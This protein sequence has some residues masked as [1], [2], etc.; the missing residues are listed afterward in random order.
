MT[1]MLIDVL[2]MSM[3]KVCILS[4]F[5]SLQAD[6][7]KKELINPLDTLIHERVEIPPNGRLEGKKLTNRTRGRLTLR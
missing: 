4:E 6:P 5:P 2:I 1:E 3:Q 7:R